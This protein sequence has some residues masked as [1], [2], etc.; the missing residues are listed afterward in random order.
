MANKGN[1]TEQDG[2]KPGDKTQ[3]ATAETE[4][5]KKETTLQQLKSKVREDDPKPSST[6]TLRKIIG[7]D[8]LTAEMVRSQMGIFAI[9]VLFTITYV[10]TRFQC[11]QDIIEIDRLE[12]EL[13]DAKY[14]ALSS[15]S[16]LTERCRESHV[17]EILRMNKDSLLHI[18]EQPPYIIITEE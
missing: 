7:G 17:L 1:G 3:T 16:A 5:D 6:L 15:S 9:I 14:K 4:K 12:R 11:Q 8:I 18:A 13:K 10:A 2:I